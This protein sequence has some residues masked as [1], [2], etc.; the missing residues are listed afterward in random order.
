MSEKNYMAVSLACLVYGFGEQAE[1]MG[2]AETKA[3][4]FALAEKVLPL[5][6]YQTIISKLDEQGRLKISQEELEARFQ[7][8]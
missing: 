4:A 1:A 8:T 6:R 7:N 2:D 3:K 5:D